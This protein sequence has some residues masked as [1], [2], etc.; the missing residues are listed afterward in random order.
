M[1]YWLY[2]VNATFTHF[3]KMWGARER[4]NGRTLNPYAVPL[5]AN[6]CAGDGSGCE[7][8]HPLD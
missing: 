7:N 3:V 8:M 1:P 4:P 5:N 6:L 2:G